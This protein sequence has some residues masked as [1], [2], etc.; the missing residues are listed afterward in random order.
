[1]SQSSSWASLTTPLEI[2]PLKDYVHEIMIQIDRE[3]IEYS[4]SFGYISV[5]RL[6]I[7]VHSATD[8]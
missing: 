3:T 7:S 5:T 2:V 6:F 8:N 4:D 1:M